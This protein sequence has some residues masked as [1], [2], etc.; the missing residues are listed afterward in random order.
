MASTQ[1][2]WYV[3]SEECDGQKPGAAVWYKSSGH[4][5]QLGDWPHQ[6][7]HLAWV[8]IACGVRCSNTTS[9]YSNDPPNLVVW[10]NR[11]Y[12][13]HAKSCIYVINEKYW[14]L[15]PFP[16]PRVFLAQESACTYLVHRWILYP[17]GHW[18][19]YIKNIW[20]IQC[21][22]PFLERFFTTMSQAVSILWVLIPEAC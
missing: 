13:M 18:E 11:A 8:I 9:N 19:I 3:D 6:Q 12:Y 14:S 22:Y 15:G 7:Y 4:T 10:H 21:R 2:I 1:W 17:T 5:E 20:V 16:S